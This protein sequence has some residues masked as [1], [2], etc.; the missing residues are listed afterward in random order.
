VKS[1]DQFVTECREKFDSYDVKAYDRSGNKSYKFE[2]ESRRAPKRKK[3]FSEGSVVDALQEMSGLNKCKVSTFY[4][5]IDQLNNALK[6]RIKPYSFVQQRF[7]VLTEF[8]SMSDEDIN[9]AIERLVDNYPKHL[10][11]STQNS[12]SLFADTRNSQ[13]IQ[14][15]GVNRNCS[16]Y[17]KFLH[18]NGVYTAFPNTE[19]IFRIYLSLLSTNCS[20]ERSFS[21]LARIKNVKQSTMSQDRLGV[22][23]LLCIERELLHKTDFSSVV[24]EFA[25]IKSRKVT[26]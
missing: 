19:V 7:G 25:T 4:V 5:I 13:K 9:I 6:Q 18:T 3:H 24:D 20:G 17:F 10:S 2:S 26:I 12:V 11:H 1:L 21:Q 15:R 16:T 14:Q 22:L 8:D 23:A